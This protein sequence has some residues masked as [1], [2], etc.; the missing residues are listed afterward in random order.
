MTDLEKCNRVIFDNNVSLKGKGL[1][2]LIWD[3]TVGDIPVTIGNLDKATME[4]ETSLRSGLKELIDLGYIEMVRLRDEK[5]Q[6]YTKT[7]YQIV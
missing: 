2:M 6:R 4:G 7:I 3:F 1:Y 5:N